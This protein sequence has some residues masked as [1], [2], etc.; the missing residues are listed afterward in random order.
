MRLG[1]SLCTLALVFAAGASP[2]AAQLPALPLPDVI[3]TVE[4]TTKKVV[5]DTKKAVEDT[6]RTVREV[7]DRTV[8]PP[9]PDPGGGS[10]GGPGGGGG[11]GDNP[12]G[13]GPG[14]EDGPGDGGG[15]DGRPV[16]EDPGDD[17]SG[18]GPGGGR[19]SDGGGS[20][21][22]AKDGQGLRETSGVLGGGEGGAA[23]VVARP[24]A[25]SDRVPPAR[26]GGGS[27]LLAGDTRDVQP[28]FGAVAAAKAGPFVL[29]VLA[30]ALV[31]LV[32]GTG[33]GLR[34]LHGRLRGA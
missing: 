13:G 5:E 19:G 31:C 7:V 27:D 25:S 26:P 21:P 34:A 12:G 23:L 9:A 28:S 8:H 16:D 18:G 6:E 33:G 17:D 24:L 11:P 20:G 15:D 4:E 1:V 22:G 14:D 29:A 2:A 10:G 32:V 3:E 30:L